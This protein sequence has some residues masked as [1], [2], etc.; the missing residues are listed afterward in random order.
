MPQPVSFEEFV[1]RVKSANP[2]MSHGDAL[3]QIKDWHDAGDPEVS[4][5]PDVKGKILNASL[6]GLYHGLVA[7]AAETIDQPV[8]GLAQMVGAA[9]GPGMVHD[10]AESVA[11][12]F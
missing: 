12:R 9:T 6:S 11:G 10:T 1:D 8:R 2:Q 7:G 3:R 4:A 5:I